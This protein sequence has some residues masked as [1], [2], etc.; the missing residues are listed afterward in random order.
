MI[1]Q[2]LK[3]LFIVCIVSASVGYIGAEATSRTFAELFLISTILQFLF[4]WFYNSILSYVT[5]VRL[6]KDNLETLKLINTNNVIIECGACKKVNTV[7][8]NLSK[9]NGFECEH[10]K[11]GNILNIEYKTI[12]KTKIYE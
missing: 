6:E 2:I 10:C 1:T 11:T 9:E 8:V 12:V 5:R 7:R 4:F 3:S